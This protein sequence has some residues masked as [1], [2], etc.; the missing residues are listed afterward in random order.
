MNWRAVGGARLTAFNRGNFG[1]TAIARR[2]VNHNRPMPHAYEA[3]YSIANLKIAK[4]LLECQMRSISTSY[5]IQLP[6]EVHSGA[7]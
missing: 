1:A 7:P 4:L 6:S 5:D 2:T 3:K